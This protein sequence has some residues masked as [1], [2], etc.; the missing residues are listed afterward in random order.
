MKNN[1]VN[2]ISQI[3][4]LADPLDSEKGLFNEGSKAISSSSTTSRSTNKSYANTLMKIA[5]KSSFRLVLNLTDLTSKLK[6]LP[7][8]IA[9]SDLT[10]HRIFVHASRVEF[11]WFE[12]IVLLK[13]FRFYLT[14]LCFRNINCFVPSFNLYS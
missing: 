6:N 2:S 5:G 4:T 7:R 14:I 12:I 10:Y 1:P 9:T 3:D 13:T 11:S 8:G